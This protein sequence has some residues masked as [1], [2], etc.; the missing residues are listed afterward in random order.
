MEIIPYRKELKKDFI[1]LNLGWLNRYF[2]VEESDRE[3]FDN[4][5]KY[6][7]NGSEIF[8]AIEDNDVLA[9]C[10]AVPV[11]EGVYEICKLAASGQYTGKGAGSAVFKACM[12]YAKEKGAKKIIIISNTKL[13]HALHIYRKFGFVEVPLDN[14]H[15]YERADIAFEYIVG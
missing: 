1:D 6:L 14:F 13:A 3:I 5:E 2:T 8:F 7:A 15:N 4:V 11:S 9:T 12:D 10:M